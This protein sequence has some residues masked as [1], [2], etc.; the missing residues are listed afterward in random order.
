MKITINVDG[1]PL[2]KS[3]SQQFWPI[4][5]LILPYDNVF[6]IGFYYGYEKPINSNDFLKQ[7]VNEAKDMCEND[8]ITSMIVILIA[9]LRL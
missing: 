8:I 1:L 7:F 2:S 5:G 9:G 3:S 6:I 4:L